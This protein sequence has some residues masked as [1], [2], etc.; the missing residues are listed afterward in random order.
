MCAKCTILN[1]NE[2]REAQWAVCVASIEF[3]GSKSRYVCIEYAKR[4]DRRTHYNLI[5]REVLFFAENDM[6]LYISGNSIINTRKMHN[7]HHFV[8]C[9]TVQNSN[10]RN[11]Q[12]KQ[13]RPLASFH[14]FSGERST[15]V[16]LINPC[17][18]GPVYIRG[19][20]NTNMATDASAPGR[21]RA[22]SGHNCVLWPV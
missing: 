14:V 21:R 18:A 7:F 5:T 13:P 6:S 12:W 8:L 9:I 16:E 3:H 11:P 1:S 19:I 2:W 15:R 20:Q 10:Y 17:H 4:H 22:I